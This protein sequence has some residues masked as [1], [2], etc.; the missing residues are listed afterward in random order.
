M[1]TRL[2]EKGR[3]SREYSLTGRI[4]GG[5][6]LVSISFDD[7]CGAIIATKLSHKG[8]DSAKAEPIANP[9]AAEKSCVALQ[10]RNTPWPP[11]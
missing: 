6:C 3:I 9:H 7:H 4:T 8:L 10:H 2:I 5:A 1:C 11:N